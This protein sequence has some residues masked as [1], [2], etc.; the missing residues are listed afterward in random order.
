VVGNRLHPSYPVANRSMVGR[1]VV[2]RLTNQADT[3]AVG[4][5]RIC[6]GKANKAERRLVPQRVKNQK[7]QLVVPLF[8][9]GGGWLCLKHENAAYGWTIETDWG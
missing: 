1:V 4:S 7:T 9:K 6:I 5:S 3:K 8:I 2:L